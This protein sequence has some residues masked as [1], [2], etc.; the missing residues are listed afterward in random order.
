MDEKFADREGLA[1]GVM[2]TPRIL[3]YMVLVHQK[4]HLE[5]IKE[6]YLAV[7][8]SIKNQVS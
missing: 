8:S 1:N 2:V 7:V 5:V 4:H 6:R 3:L